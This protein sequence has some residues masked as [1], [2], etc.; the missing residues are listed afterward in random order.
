MA[1]QKIN[2]VWARGVH[3]VQEPIRHHGARRAPLRHSAM[4]Q[5]RR[6]CRQPFGCGVRQ[7]LFASD[8][9]HYRRA[10]ERLAALEGGIVALA[11]ARASPR[12]APSSQHPRRAE[13]SSPPQSLRGHLTLF[14]QTSGNREWR[15]GS[16]MPIIRADPSPG[17]CKYPPGVPGIGG[18]PKND[19][20]ISAAS[21]TS[22]MST[23][24]R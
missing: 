24:C 23:I 8:E 14:T 15:S 5:R 3:A 13:T 9:P 2:A 16:S 17:G 12:Y 22:P 19:V 18:Q 4:S 7:Y 11:F 10:G 21:R 1:K 6:S 20:P